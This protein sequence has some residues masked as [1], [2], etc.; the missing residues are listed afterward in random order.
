MTASASSQ[1]LT[2]SGAGFVAG[3]GLKVTVGAASYVPSSVSSTQLVVSVNVGTTAQTLAVQVTN[4][5][6]QASN[7]VELTVS[8]PVVAPVITTLSPNPMT[9]SNSGQILTINGSGFLA[10][11]KLLIGSTAISASQLSSLTATQLQV[12]VI[13]GLTAYTYPVQVVNANGGTS[14]SVS[15]QVNAPLVPAIA[16]L[17]PNPMT[18][19]AAAQTLTINGTNFQSGTGLKVTLAGTSSAGTTTYS[20]A[21]VTFVSSTQLKVTVTDAPGA[22]TLGVQVTNPSGAVSNTA[23][24]TVH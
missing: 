10:G 22:K 11:L 13:T 17:S 14:N 18:G 1:S 16:S 7:Q 24:L 20:G 5:N 15:L 4:P 3:T 12:N 23:T 19:A 6:G 9:G 8:V 2:I 21:Q